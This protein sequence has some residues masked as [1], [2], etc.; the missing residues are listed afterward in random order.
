MQ[1]R[2]SDCAAILQTKLMFKSA[3]F[4]KL[5]AQILTFAN[6]LF[7]WKKAYCRLIYYKQ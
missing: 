6:N 3:W 4:L 7:S 5:W 2:H 1:L